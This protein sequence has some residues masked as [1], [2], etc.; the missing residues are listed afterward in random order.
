MSETTRLVA[1]GRATDW[2][3]DRCGS[4]LRNVD[5]LLT[6]FVLPILLMLM[7]VYLFG[8]AIHTGTRYVDYVVPGCCWCASASA[9]R[10]PRQR[11]S[12]T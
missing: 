3:S 6:A 9:P 8:G 11:R 4:S 2:S 10:R 5:A 12:R 7:F 1:G